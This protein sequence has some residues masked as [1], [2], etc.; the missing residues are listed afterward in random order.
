MNS[1]SNKWE[2][3]PWN[4]SDAIA[5]AQLAGFETRAVMPIVWTSIRTA[6]PFVFGMDV[7]KLIGADVEFHATHGGEDM[8]LMQL[9]WHG[10][11]D[12]PEWRLATRPCDAVDQQWE[13]WGYFEDL[14]EAWTVPASRP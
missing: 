12:P 5:D 8:I 13:S 11:P 3:D 14:P 6:G 1:A 4:A 2:A 9:A 7:T 10:F